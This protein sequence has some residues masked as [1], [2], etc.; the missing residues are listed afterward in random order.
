MKQ[1]FAVQ[2]RIGK[3]LADAMQSV[4]Q[5]HGVAIYLE[6]HH[7]CVEMR[8][9]REMSP[10]TRTTNWRGFYEDDPALRAEFFVACG[11]HSIP[12]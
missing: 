4:M 5:P 11:I 8:G 7:L 6:A 12:R 1:R 9:V 2:E 3:Q 10:V